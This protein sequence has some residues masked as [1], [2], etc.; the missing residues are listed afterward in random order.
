MPRTKAAFIRYDIE[1]PSSLFCTGL[2]SDYEI[3]VPC[4]CPIE[5][6]IESF[7]HYSEKVES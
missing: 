5:L 2:P 6:K 3:V 7:R 1:G 4:S